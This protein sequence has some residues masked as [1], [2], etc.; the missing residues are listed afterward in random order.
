MAQVTSRLG[1]TVLGSGSQGNALVVHSATEALLVD[2]GFT[3]RELQRRLGEAGLDP[4]LLKAILVSH[5]HADHVRGL[6]V[7]ARHYGIPVYCNRLTAEVLRSRDEDLGQITIFAVG[8]AFRV[9]E[10]E[11]EPFSIPHDANDPV[12]FVIRTAGFKI[13]LATDLGHASHLVCHHLQAC[14]LL[15]VESNH[16]IAMLRDSTRPWP[17]KQRILGRHGHLSNAD[18]M[19]L[20]KRVV[21]A[22][23]RF[24]VLAHA[25]TEC[26]RYELVERYAADCLAGLG[27]PD[28]T[29]RVARQDTWLPTLWL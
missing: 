16:E 20:L 8:A 23:T 14:D 1:V 28:V 2:A 26:N 12:G 11:V 5:E 6:G 25:S 19:D 10:F 9:G 7:S 21:H 18:S 4:G 15:V 17:L 13:G 27:R 3:A 24:L 29:I 22:R